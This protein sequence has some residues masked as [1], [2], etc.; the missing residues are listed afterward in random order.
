[1]WIFKN[2]IKCE[3]IECRM[4]IYMQNIDIENRK[5][6]DIENMYMQNIEKENRKQVDIE[7]IAM[8]NIDMH[9]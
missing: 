7:N 1:M 3:C 4:Y 8:Q 9:A 5:Y 2:T 6:D